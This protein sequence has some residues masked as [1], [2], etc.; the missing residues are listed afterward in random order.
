[1]TEKMKSQ[2][3]QPSLA[4]LARFAGAAVLIVVSM[5]SISQAQVP[6]PPMED[7]KQLQADAKRIVEDAKALEAKGQLKEA[8]E[9]YLAAEAITSTKEGA[10]GLERVRQ[11]RAKKVQTL[12]TESHRLYDAGKTQEAIAK[13][14]EAEALEPTEVAIHYNLALGYTK[15]DN[16]SKA[17]SELDQCLQILPNDDKNRAQLEQMKS[18]LITGEKSQQLTPE[19][20]TKIDGFN[21][22]ALEQARASSGLDQQDEEA[23]PAA[24]DAK[25]SPVPCAQLRDL[26]SSLPKSAALYFNLAKCAEEDGR[27]DDA[28]HYL[29]Q[30]M[31][32]APAALDADDVKLRLTTDS[33]LS[34]LSGP[35]GEQVRK[36]Y[37]EASREIDQRKYN[38]ALADLTKADQVKPDYPLTKWRL[39]L[40]YEAQGNVAKAREFYSAYQSLEASDQGRKE[41]G[42]R[43]DNLDKERSQYDSSLQ[44]GRALLMPLLLKSM[45]IESGKPA[46]KQY[47]GGA[48]AM[49][50]MFGRAPVAT[51][52]GN[53]SYSYV[54]E[55]INNARAKLD[56]AASTFPLGPEVN[57]LLAFIYMQGNNPAAAM[58]CFDIV[59]SQSLPVSFYAKAFTAHDRKN[60]HNVKLELTRDNARMIYLAS[61]DPKKKTFEPPAKP[62]GP[63]KLGALTVAKAD[64]IL[65]D[66]DGSSW[67][68]GDLKAVETKNNYVMLKAGD[69]E[70]FLEP[71]NISSDTPYQGKAARK[72]GNNYSRLFLRFMGYDATKLGPEH[73]TGG[74]KFSLGMSLAAAGMGGYS[75]LA[76]G[77]MMMS[78]QL[79]YSMAA[80]NNAMG[81]LRQNRVE[82]RQLIEG[83]DFKIIPSQSFDLAY[84]E[85]FQ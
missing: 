75:A 1:M 81:T 71:L 34:G 70:L 79:M 38:R 36:L 53:M 31:A 8:E 12:L 77:G 78:S 41:A 18:A 7:A 5:V 49:G 52:I 82:Q 6:N 68:T 46:G 4:R 62:A 61:Y 17:L 69:D 35:S 23:K 80:L 26:E 28:L 57:E 45:N 84:R 67:K 10:G 48:M 44:E 73:M 3:W 85:K 54:R 29:N 11:D 27:E 74:E 76:T 55:T 37:A 64:E 72:F 40:L 56:V 63:D 24:V 58:R 42:N 25:A 83:N 66:T 30:Y 39:A 16:K 15:L 50:M 33:S 19:Q 65:S 14:E 21:A 20:K 32:M 2:G 51:G 43:L 9:K 47:G 60:L 13:L 22:S 59:A